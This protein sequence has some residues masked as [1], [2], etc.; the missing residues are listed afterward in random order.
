[1]E[2]KSFKELMFKGTVHE[3]ENT[4]DEAW[5]RQDLMELL[6]ELDQGELEEVTGLVLEILDYDSETDSWMDIMSITDDELDGEM[7][8][9]M[10]AQAKKK[11]KKLRKKPAFKKAKRM[12][13]RCMDH[14]GDQVKK[15]KGKLTCGNDGKIKKGMSKA[16][17]REMAKAKKR[18]VGRIIA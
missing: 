15:S 6:E 16:K 3:D 1:M 9:R 13:D 4:G 14:H 8:E 10:S 5:T 12:K 7:T 17:K 11:T 18:N 2:L